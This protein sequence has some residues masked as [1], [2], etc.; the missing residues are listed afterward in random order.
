MNPTF[1]KTAEQFVQLERSSWRTFQNFFLF[2]W[3][4]CFGLDPPEQQNPKLPYHLCG[5][6]VSEFLKARIYY[7]HLSA[8]SINMFI[9]DQ[10]NVLMYLSAFL[11]AC[12][13]SL[14]SG[15]CLSSVLFP[16][17]FSVC[18][19]DC[20]LPAFSHS[21]LRISREASHKERILDSQAPVNT[22]YLQECS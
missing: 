4:S 18:C 6:F 15:K 7:F 20:P 1:P 12:T 11:Q 17:P 19:P 21:Y 22:H 2:I 5:H 9:S 13:Q 10:Y 14:P 8:F 3:T 16:L